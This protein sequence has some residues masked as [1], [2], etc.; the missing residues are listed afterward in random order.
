MGCQLRHF[1]L[2][3]I[4]HLNNE[5]RAYP[6]LSGPI[7]PGLSPGLSGRK[8]PGRDRAPLRAHS[9]HSGYSG[10]HGAFREARRAPPLSGPPGMPRASRNTR[11]TRNGPG[12]AP[13]LFRVLCARKDPERDP[14]RPGK[15]R[16]GPV[17]HPVFPWCSPAALRIRYRSEATCHAST[18]AKIVGLLLCHSL[19]NHHCY[20]Y[21]VSIIYYLTVCSVN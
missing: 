15:T 17:N 8:A 19:V 3:T 16:K 14:E 5:S 7:H 6:G 18:C 11:N 4:G 21:R 1:Q 9:G 13:G 10:R 20:V 2:D 12:K